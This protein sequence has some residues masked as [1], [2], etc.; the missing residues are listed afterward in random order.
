[1]HKGG[2]QRLPHSPALSQQKN[3][4]NS[5]MSILPDN[6]PITSLQIVEDSERCPKNFLP[7][8]KTYDQDADADLW[9]ETNLLFGKQTSRYLCLSKSEG[10][11]D[12]VVETLSVITEKE[13][14]PRDFS[15][16]SRTADS[17]Q[18]AW[19][20]K[21]IIY[22]LSKKG[23]VTSAVTDIILC[24]KLKT[25]P[26]GFIMGG[27]I[28]GIL[29]CYKTGPLPTRLPPPIPEKHIENIESALN[30]ISIYKKPDYL[31]SIITNDHEY[32]EISSYN[33][34]TSPKRPAPRPPMTQLSSGTLGAYSDM[35]GVPFM[36]NPKLSQ[37]FEMPKLATIPNA[38]DLNYDFQLERQILC[39]TKSESTNLKN[40]FFK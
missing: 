30:S 6:R 28:N 23:T 2:K 32:E 34:I 18:K 33:K 29:V 16:L 21:Q 20:K 8:S 39:T 25:A 11:P 3:V 24:S 14:A 15:L 37:N 35:E 22:K 4:I 38:S 1:M 31:N 27:E 12:Y 19:R 13:V 17:E 10:L 40:P 9:R 26:E 7:I 5:I 36:L